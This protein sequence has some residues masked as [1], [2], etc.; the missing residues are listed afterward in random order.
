MGHVWDGLADFLVC[1]CDAGK[2]SQQPQSP[3]QQLPSGN[4]TSTCSSIVS[5]CQFFRPSRL[6]DWRRLVACPLP[7]YQNLTSARVRGYNA[8]DYFKLECMTNAKIF[9]FAPHSQRQRLTFAPIVR[10]DAAQP[11][12]NCFEILQT[13]LQKLQF[14]SEQITF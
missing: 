1:R 4:C 11:H 10:D 14:W 12:L 8:Q 5:I 7:I 3:F 2:V 9:I 13:I 6:L